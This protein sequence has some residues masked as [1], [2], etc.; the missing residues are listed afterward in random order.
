MVTSP[1]DRSSESRIFVAFTVSATV[2][3]LIMTAAGLLASFEFSYPDLGSQAWMSFG[4]L[5][6]MHTNGTFFGWATMALIGSAMWAVARS[7]G[8]RLQNQRFAWAAMWLFN[9]ATVLGSI[10]LG[11]RAGGRRRERFD[12]RAAQR[13]RRRIR[14][15]ND[16]TANL[17]RQLRRLSRCARW[18]RARRLSRPRRRSG[19]HR[20][21]RQG[22][23][24]DGAPWLARQSHWRQAVCGRDAGVS[25]ATQRCGSR[26][27]HRSR[28][29]VMGK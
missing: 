1:P 28:T 22:A 18:R 5:R 29:D 11:Q 25:H 4:R 9:I 13:Q 15:C 26:S 27:G 10:T 17:R 2:W 8:V 7:S 6:A 24:Y 14:L 20:C 19:R 12:R 3:L 23:H 21:R 16:G